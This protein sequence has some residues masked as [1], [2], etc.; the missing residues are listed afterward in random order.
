M[1][2]LQRKI[3]DYLLG[4][5]EG[6]A[7]ISFEEQLSQDA[8]LQQEVEEQKHAIQNIE[9]LEDRKRKN[10]LE[11]IHANYIVQSD[12]AKRSVEPNRAR[13]FFWYLVGVAAA[14]GL[15]LMV[16]YFSQFQSPASLYEQN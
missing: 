7:L 3:D 10:R 5:L 11:L 6:D 4:R 2:D 16:Y 8:Q 13:P 1:E 9:R 15:L 14:V 12:L